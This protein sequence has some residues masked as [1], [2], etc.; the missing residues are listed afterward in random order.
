[1]ATAKTAC[2]FKIH[3]AL[4]SVKEVV[5]VDRT[6]EFQ[7]AS[8]HGFAREMIDEPGV[9][10]QVEDAWRQVLGETV[11]IRCVLQG[12]SRQA[13]KGGEKRESTGGDVLLEDAKRRGAVV[14]QLDQ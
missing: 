13:G 11:S 6:L 12:A 5:V 4:R 10:T 8:S 14:K 1:M 3:A 9:K 7:F 2:G